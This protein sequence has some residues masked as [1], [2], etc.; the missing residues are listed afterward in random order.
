MTEHGEDERPV[1]VF[2]LVRRSAG[3]SLRWVTDVRVS[4]R[5]RVCVCVFVHGRAH[6]CVHACVYCSL[7]VNNFAPTDKSRNKT[8][9]HTASFIISEWDDW[10]IWCYWKACA[11]H[12]ALWTLYDVSYCCVFNFRHF[13]PFSYAARLVFVG[14]R[15]F[16]RLSWLFFC[17]VGTGYRLC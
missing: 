5:V 1:A 10:C 7:C 3:F 2:S 12:V 9:T 4:L 14:T 6:V 16:W 17:H 8:Q 11:V 15:C 13:E